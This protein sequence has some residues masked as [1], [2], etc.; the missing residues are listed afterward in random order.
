MLILPFTHNAQKGLGK[1]FIYVMNS[2]TFS[3]SLSITIGFSSGN[4]ASLLRNDKKIHCYGNKT[5]LGPIK[6][7]KY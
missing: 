7:S 3:V 5:Y 2:L 6:A 4:V 1:E